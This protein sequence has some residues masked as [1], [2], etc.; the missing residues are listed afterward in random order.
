VL[1]KTQDT[2]VFVTS[3][4]ATAQVVATDFVAA[5]GVVHK[6]NGVLF[7]PPAAVCLLPATYEPA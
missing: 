7:A 3:N 6:I 4:G 2:G 1:T 5:N